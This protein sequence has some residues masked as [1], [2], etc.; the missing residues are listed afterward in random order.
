M[1]ITVILLL[2]LAF[3]KPLKNINRYYYTIYAN[4]FTDNKNKYIYLIK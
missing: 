1:F 4:T 3:I 2:L